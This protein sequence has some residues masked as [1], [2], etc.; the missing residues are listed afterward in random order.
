[1]SRLGCYDAN[2]HRRQP[3]ATN[4]KNNCNDNHLPSSG[5]NSKT[6]SCS[7]LGATDRMTPSRLSKNVFNVPKECHFHFGVCENRGCVFAL[8]CKTERVRCVVSR[9][10]FINFVS[11]SVCVSGSC[12][13]VHST[14]SA[15]RN[16]VCI[17]YILD[18]CDRI[19]QTTREEMKARKKNCRK[20][21]NTCS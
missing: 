7:M 5:A 21:L 10:H 14:R 3:R 20:N 18:G 19:H 1:M 6:H 16:G 15:V 2:A 8:R 12:V 17:D 11:L 9:E 13:C 4:K